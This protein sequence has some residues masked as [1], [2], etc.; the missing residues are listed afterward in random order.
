MLKKG[1]K[2]QTRYAV[3]HVGDMSVNMSATSQHK[4]VELVGP[5]LTPW[6]CV[7]FRHADMYGSRNQYYFLPFSL[8]NKIIVLPRGT[9]MAGQR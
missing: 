3:R 8:A 2:R 5:T 4:Y 6:V 7:N 9:K 1:P